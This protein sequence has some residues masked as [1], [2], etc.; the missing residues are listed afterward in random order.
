MR[1]STERAFAHRGRLPA[2]DTLILTRRD[3]VA[4]LP[5]EDCIRSVEE[6]LE[7]HAAGRSIPPSVLGVASVDGGFHL[8]AAGLKLERTWFAVKCNGNFP[9]NRERFGLPTI[10][11]LILLCDGDDGTPLAVMDS[12]E[13]TTLRTAAATAVAAKHLARRDAGVVTIA[14]CGIQGR[15]QLRALA[16]VRPLE[17]V[18]AF[19]SDEALARAFA[20]EMT[21]ETR[22]DVEAVARLGVAVQDSDICVT[23]TP[24][25][26]YILDADDVRP[27]TF[28]AGVGADSETKWEID[29]KLFAR[30]RVVVDNLDQCASIGD[31]HH[32]LDHRTI[33]RD[34]VHAEL[35]DLVSGRAAGRETQD[36]I[37]LFDSTGIALEDIG[38]ALMVYRRAIERGFGTRVEFTTQARVGD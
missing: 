2:R 33:A 24:A 13:I 21:T 27:G 3:V 38:A 23:C 25:N 7:H 31:L 26:R 5:L 11:G 19:D 1:F 30:A 29:A 37:T 34:E 18:F 12:A 22:L 6:A 8:K 15:A 35:S 28:V 20:D 16:C 4:A 17:R 32:A 14:G 9:L 10:Q 36:E